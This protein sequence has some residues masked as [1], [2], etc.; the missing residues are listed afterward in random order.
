MAIVSS[1][2]HAYGDVNQ[3]IMTSVIGTAVPGTP[4]PTAWGAGWYDLGWLDNDAGLTENSDIQQTQKYGWQGA[5]LLRILRSQAQKTFTFNALEENA[6]TLGLLRPAAGQVTTGATAEVQTI[7]I[8]GAPTGGTFTITSIYGAYAATY[9]IATAA[10]ATALSALFGFTV[11]VSGTA[12]TSYVIT[13]P[14]SLGN[15]PLMSVSSQLTGGTTPTV[16]NA[17]TTPGVNGT[18][19][20][21]VKPF[22]GLNSRQFGIDLI[23]GSVHRRFVVLNGEATGTGSPVYKADDLTMYAFTLAAYVDSA[24]RFYQEISDNPAIGSGLFV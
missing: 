11:A 19:T 7:T 8:T 23:D 20:W 22:T 6:V 21:D 12:G 16:A 3:R 17:T 13:F 14:A 5:A 4:Y 2:A 10:L 1:N 24:G 18:T 15:V 9:N